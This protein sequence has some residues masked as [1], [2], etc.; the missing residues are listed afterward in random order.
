M[1]D[2]E[3]HRLKG[4]LAVLKDVVK[5]YPTSSIGNAIKQI[6]ARIKEIEKKIE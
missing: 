1:S 3:Y 5:D 2:Y 4:Q 6:D